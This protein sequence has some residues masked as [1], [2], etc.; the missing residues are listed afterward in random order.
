[1][2]RAASIGLGWWSDE[3]AAALQAGE[4]PEGKRS[5]SDAIKI[6][7]CFSRS[8]DKRSAFAECFACQPYE[9]Y[10]AVLGD[11]EIDAVIL[12]TPHSLHGQ[13]IEQ[14]AAAGKQVFVE[15]P[16][17]L[18]RPS[19]E[20][21]VEACRRAGVVL[22]VG[23]NRRFSPVAKEL[24]RLVDGGA[25][26]TLLHLEANFSAPGAL[27]YT[28]DRW[29]A[30]RKESPA[31]GLAGLGIHMIDLLCYLA[32]PVRE[33]RAQAVRRAVKVDLEDTTSALL[34]FASGATGYL[35]CLFACPYTSYLNVFGTK[36]NAFAWVDEGKLALQKPGGRREPV[37]LPE[38][39]TLRA[40][41]EAFAAACAGGPAYPVHP[42]EA[43]HDVAVMAAIAASAYGGGKSVQIEGVGATAGA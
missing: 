7:A 31:G 9:S 26:G 13:H 43:I 17:T 2:L 33:L 23:Q 21:A 27:S 40:E 19:A 41:L 8:A 34:A 35:G 32:G 38:R 11:P 39:D 4:G 22:A 29:R 20:R 12:T 25:F 3:L 24:K 6:V 15:K 30:S 14:A 37:A 42:E 18:D 10:E 36:A 1:M 16:M 5:A 28:P